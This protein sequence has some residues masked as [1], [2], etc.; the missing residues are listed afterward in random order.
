MSPIVLCALLAIVWLMRGQGFPD[1]APEQPVSL[2][3]GDRI[4]FARSEG[5]V[6]LV[7][8]WS[9]SCVPCIRG[10]PALVDTHNRYHSRGLDVVAVAMSYDAPSH[11]QAFAGRESLPFRVGFDPVGALARAFGGVNATPTTYL[12][13]RRGRI[14]ERI[15]GI[16]DHVALDA[17]IETLLASPR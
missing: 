8:F 17:L 9:T 6:R 13:D 4:D 11:V 1:E 16:P 2:L 7:N 10:M 3:D 15:I 14:V 5:R 12:I